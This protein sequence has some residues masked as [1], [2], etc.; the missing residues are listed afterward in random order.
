MLL[1]TAQEVRTEA[2]SPAAMLQMARQYALLGNPEEA[3]RCYRQVLANA[4]ENVE[5]LYRLASLLQQT[6]NRPEQALA[7]LENALAL[8]PG[9]AALHG[10]RALI[11]NGMNR[12]LDA[13]DAFADACCL[14]PD[15]AD[16]LYNIGLLCAELCCPA[17]AE[18]YARHLLERFPDRP[19]AHYLLLRAL[20]AL[21]ID[22]AELDAHYAFLIKADPLNVS[23]RF[24]RGLLQLKMGDYAAGWDAQEWRWELEPV[25]SSRIVCTQPRWAGTPLEGRRLLILGEQGFGDVLQFARYLPLLVARGAHVTLQLD[26]NRAPLA[27][28]LK[29]IEG[30]EIVM[31]N[32]QLPACDLYCPLAS[33]P[34]VFGTTVDTI[35]ALPYLKVDP[36]DVNVWKERLAH[37]PRPWVGL[38]WAG[39]QEHSHNVRRSLPLCAE[40]RLYHERQTREQRIGMAAARVAAALN[41][42]ALNAAARRDAEPAF[43]TMEPLLRRTAGSFVSL[44]IGPHASEIEELPS[45]LRSR[46]VAPLTGN[47]DFYDTACLVQA[48][49]EVITVDT[50]VAHV[51]GALGRPGLVI[52][53]AAP[54]WRWIERNGR[55]PWYPNLRLMA[56]HA[57]G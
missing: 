17:Q 28:L 31:G 35:P 47:P 5:A 45:D 42:D 53:P 27:R 40:S 23:L 2:L 12:P 38:C 43:F 20:T 33:L 13:L 10:T 19:S 24:A 32:S 22:S 49:D 48:L 46:T 57:I 52:K 55:S 18:V 39:S 51:T 34:Y 9:N 41:L 8:A 1:E 44:Q 26:D 7:L 14:A 50:S 56:Q 21:E 15:N 36:K 3:E 6:G 11:L 16:M 25:K 29:Q 30:L 37:L 54:E 4:P